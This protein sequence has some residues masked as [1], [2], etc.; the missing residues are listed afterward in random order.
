MA[1]AAV[2]SA[3][4]TRI[5]S[6][7]AGLCAGRS[8]AT[9]PVVYPNTGTS[10]PRDGSAFLAV[11]YPVANEE[12]KSSG[13][14]GANIWREDGAT[15]LTLCVPRGVDLLASGTPYAGLVDDLRANLRGKTLTVGSG[16]LTTF[17]ATPPAFR[18][19]SDRGAYCELSTAVAYWFDIVG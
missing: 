5:T 8:F 9:F 14:P 16:F 18:P 11:E 12:M 17:E 13:A 2:M 10:A 19:D 1:S 7:W 6:A 4:Q 3:F 15:V